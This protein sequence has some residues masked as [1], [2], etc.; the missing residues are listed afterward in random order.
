[1][2]NIIP[3]VNWLTAVLVGAFAV[4]IYLGSKSP[5]TRMYAI[6]SFFVQLWA[7]GVGAYFFT[8]D[9]RW[10]L[11]WNQYNH[12]I[13][14]LIAAS[15]YLFSIY[16]PDDTP[17]QKETVNQLILLEAVL[18]YIYFFTD[19]GIRDSIFEG[20][21]SVDRFEIFKQ[22]G[23]VFYA[24][25][26]ALFALAFRNLYR[27]IKQ[28]GPDKRAAQFVL[29]GTIIGFV[30]SITADIILPSLGYYGIYWMGPALALGWIAFILY[31]IAK[32]HIFSIRL[33]FAEVSVLVMSIILF[34]NIFLSE[35]L[36][37][38]VPGRI[39][40]FLAFAIVGG[41]FI[42]NIIQ[43]EE[44]KEKLSK[45][46]VDLSLANSELERQVA[47]RTRELSEQT[48]H[49]ETIIENLESGLIEYTN[50]F[51]VVRV[52]KKAEYLLGISRR[53]IVGKTLLP[54]HV[55]EQALASIAQVTYPVLSKTDSKPKTAATGIEGMVNEI[56]I[57]EPADRDLQI[58]TA[59]LF[60]EHANALG[61][62]KLLRD[63]TNEKLAAKSKSE[64][65]T[66]AAHQLRTPLSG[67]KWN[68]GAILAGDRGKLSLEQKVSLE[69][70]NETNEKMIT[71]VNDLL[72]VARIEDGRFG[73]DFRLGD[74]GELIK[75]VIT[76]TKIPAR[77][78]AISITH[79]AEGK[80]PAFYMDREKLSLALHNLIDNA[81]HYTHEG[82]AIR[83][84]SMVEGDSV[85]IYV[86]DTG[87]GIPAKDLGLLFT[88]FFR[89]ENAKRLRTDGSG[90]GLFIVKNIVARHGGT[91]EVQSKEHIGTTFHISLPLRKENIPEA[92]ETIYY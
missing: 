54:R 75:T 72:N 61:F 43:K 68:I 87:I 12:F 57:H 88:K 83:I 28:G 90:L 89:A 91:I 69:R 85:H 19:I 32:H 37:F 4:I 1:M 14:G 52:N 63:I 39:M 60:D 3:L 21:A 18:F 24:T 23:F 86:E 40:I 51:S 64:F 33:L 9:P 62:I 42:R 74:V 20:A 36:A 53:D 2:I 7:I 44:Q 17:P 25:F 58:V 15:Y 35:D 50:D 26:S 11:F 81:L 76:E 67:I 29:W 49:S 59:P 10:V 38:G 34:V 5:S 16:F 80:I 65:I 22:V 79:H 71:L 92:E 13:A 55:S 73:Y 46:T 31:A 6:V 45:L 70:A 82:G 56:T 41:F 78:H 47:A 27:K 66:I 77:E 48:A 84:K 30:P 8:E